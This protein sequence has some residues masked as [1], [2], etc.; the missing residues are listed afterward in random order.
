VGSWA[1]VVVFAVVVP[2]ARVVVRAVASFSTMKRTWAAF[3]STIIRPCRALGG[4]GLEDE[5][6]TRGGG[7][8]SWI[9][10]LYSIRLGDRNS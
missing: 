6:E 8:L 10:D 4:R 7:T 3:S 9:S 1:T 2:A 5:A